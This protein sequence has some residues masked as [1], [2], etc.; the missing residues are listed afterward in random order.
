MS[1]DE[2][3]NIAFPE[4]QSI[5]PLTGELYKGNGLTL[6]ECRLATRIR[7]GRRLGMPGA[8]QIMKKIDAVCGKME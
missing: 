3:P 6:P 8:V 5:K 7:L 4:L 1:S 2:N